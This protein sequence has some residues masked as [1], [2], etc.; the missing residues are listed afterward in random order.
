V[1]IYIKHSG[2]IILNVFLVS[3]QQNS[4]ASRTEKL[5]VREFLIAD[6]GGWQSYACKSL[7]CPNVVS[8]PYFVITWF[9]WVL[10]R[11]L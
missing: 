8:S 10:G 9:S 3:C 4:L 5:A 2:N 6:L 1:Y 11:T 7:M